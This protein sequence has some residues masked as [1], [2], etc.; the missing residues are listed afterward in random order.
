MTG[1]I[2]NVVGEGAEEGEVVGVV[3][4]GPHVQVLLS[5]AEQSR[6]EAF[7]DQVGVSDAW[8][9]R[10]PVGSALSDLGVHRLDLGEE[11]IE[12]LGEGVAGAEDGQVAAVVQQ[13]RGLRPPRVPV[14]PV[15][16]VR[17]I[18]ERVVISPAA[19]TP[20]RRSLS[21][22]DTAG[23]SASCC[24]AW[25][26]RAGPS[27]R[28]VIAKPRRA[29]SIVAGAGSGADLAVPSTRTIPVSAIRSSYSSGG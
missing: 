27:S 10:R 3:V 15:P 6:R 23:K 26:A 11:L 29:R 17:R 9:W 18:G 24:W 16:G 28:A 25:S 8:R 2:R 22:S 14:E 21:T 12:P 19:A 7:G 13:G 1:S 5:Q 4:Q 20:R